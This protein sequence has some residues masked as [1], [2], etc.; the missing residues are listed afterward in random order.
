MGIII[1]GKIRIKFC[2]VREYGIRGLL[3]EVCV[4]WEEKKW[5]ENFDVN[6]LISVV[7]K[8]K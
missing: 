4:F 1:E 2:G 8:V 6:F 3:K 5:R 7:I